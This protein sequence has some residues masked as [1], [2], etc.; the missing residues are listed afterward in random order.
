MLY[1]QNIEKCFSDRATKGALKKDVFESNLAKIK[2]AKDDIKKYQDGIAKAILESPDNQDIESIKEV[3][4]KIRNGFK[5]LVIFGTGGSTLN[6]QSVVALQQEINPDFK[7]YFADNIDPIYMESLFNGIDIKI[8]AFLAISKSGGTVETVS[9]MLFALKK[10]EQAGVSPNNS[11]FVIT[12]P[13]PSIIRNIG[14]EIGATILNHDEKIGGRFSTFTNVSLLPA[15]IAGLDAELFCKGASEA[16]E[17]F[18]SNNNSYPEEGAAL[19]I[20]AMDAGL[21]VNVVMP[22]VRMLKPFTAWLSQ[23]WAES[24]GKGGHGST[25]LQALGT[26][27]QH[28]QLQLYLDGPNDKLFNI[29]GLHDE[30]IGPAISS[31]FTS[32]QN[33]EYL[34]GKTFAQIN[35][36]SQSG[37]IAALE[38]KNRPVREITIERVDEESLGGLMMYFTIETILTA[39]VLGINAFDQPAVEDGKVRARKI[40]GA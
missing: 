18:F 9:Q 37:T 38:A 19:A 27:D 21:G 7:I 23:I 33:I 35:M 5:A 10:I 22:Y 2:A 3:A 11:F 13:N 36:A 17:E 28:S 12:E 15:L 29:I 26:I 4:K 30:N 8:T 16:V 24:L 25:P 34:E 32:S 39:Q 40:L 14:E 6:P 31:K 20:T 1:T